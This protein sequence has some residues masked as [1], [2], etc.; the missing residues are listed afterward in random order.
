MEEPVFLTAL[1]LTD[2]LFPS[3]GYSHSFGLESYVQEG[4]VR[5]RASFQKLASSMLVFSVGSCDA[6]I[7]KL[8]HQD[9]EKDSLD[10]LIGFDA[11]LESMKVVKEFREG[12]RQIGR[13]LLRTAKNLWEDR[14]IAEFSDVMEE[15]RC[16]GHYPV[17]FALV[18]KAAGLSSREAILAYLYLFLSGLTSAALRLVPLG[19]SDGQRAIKELQP[20][21][22]AV[23]DTALAAR[24]EDLFTFTPALDIRGMRHERL[25]SRL[26]RS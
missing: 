10:D 13:S 14:M 6:V 16:F 5:D 17:V 3:G 19:Q 9:L 8:I 11:M 20:V 26:F 23:T 24:K 18:S 7:I 22:I 1:Q 15:G 21:L 2:T 25:Y 4:V 12:S